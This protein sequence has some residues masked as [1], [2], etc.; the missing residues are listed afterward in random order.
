ML[1]VFTNYK[2]YH[3]LKCIS[4]NCLLCL[5]N[6]NIYSQLQRQYSLYSNDN[7]VQIEEYK[8]KEEK[9]EEQIKDLDNNMP[10]SYS[11]ENVK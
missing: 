4:I 3:I 1:T 7:N 11:R 8:E 5:F 6:I 9:I 2:I 10:K